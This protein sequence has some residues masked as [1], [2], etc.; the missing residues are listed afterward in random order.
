MAHRKIK[1]RICKNMQDMYIMDLLDELFIGTAIDKG[2]EGKD[3]QIKFDNFTVQAK[4]KNILKYKPE[5]QKQPNLK[6]TAYLDLYNYLI[7]KGVITSALGKETF[8]TWDSVNKINQDKIKSLDEFKRLVDDYIT[9]LPCYDLD[10][11]ALF[12]FLKTYK[13]NSTDE[14]TYI[15][16]IVSNMKSKQK[17]KSKR[18]SKKGGKRTKYQKRKNTLRVMR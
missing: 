2:I 10:K 14:L 3:N 11:V 17:S 5:C 6:D 16:N 8:I 18:A 4:T 1:I 15:R 12:N 9:V 13:Y 7:K